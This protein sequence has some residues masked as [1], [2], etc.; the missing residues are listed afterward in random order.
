MSFRAWISLITLILLGCVV[1]FGWPE[2]LRAINLMGSVNLWILALLIPIQLFSYYAA[3]ETIF[4]YLRS[5]GEL[6]TISRAKMTRLALEANFVNHIVPVPGAAGFSYFGWVLHHY[7]VSVSRSTMAQI[8]KITMMFMSFVV[9]MI[10]AVIVLV[11]DNQVNRIIIALTLILIIAVIIL[12]VVLVYVIGNRNRIIKASGWVARV[13]NIFVAKITFGKKNQILKLDAVEKF[14]T[15][16]HQDFLAIKRDKKIL[17]QPFLWS[18]LANI[19][20]VALIGAAFLSLGFWVNPVSLFIAF[21]LSSLVSIFAV[22][23]GGTGVYEAIMIAFL[24]MAGVPPDVSIAGTLLARAVLLA[25]TI[26]F[27]YIFYQ[28]TINKYGKITQPTDL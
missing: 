1:Y 14:F 27:G 3:G 2:I 24:S 12:T 11:F 4:S 15:E 20:D 10:L 22:T 8:I 25:G 6:K 28:L 7:G 19:L 16:I 17:I 5:K 23:P 21:G 13:I 9:V 18:T 26:L